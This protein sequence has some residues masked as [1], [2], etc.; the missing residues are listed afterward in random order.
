[1]ASSSGRQVL[2]KARS[3]FSSTRKLQSPSNLNGLS[4]AST[5]PSSRLSPRRNPL[6]SSREPVELACAQSLMPLHSVTASSL[7][8]SMLSSKVGQWSSLSEG[9]ATP[10]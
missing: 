10:L 1:M 7:L 5:T 2:Q 4:P 6:F 3:F 8:K 9:F